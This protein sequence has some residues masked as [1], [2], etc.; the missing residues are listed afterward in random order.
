[1]LNAA[2]ENTPGLDLRPGSSLAEIL[3]DRY[4]QALYG[5]TGRV[6]LGRV[7]MFWPE[8]LPPTVRDALHVSCHAPTKCAKQPQ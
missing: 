8:L 6:K 7:R 5:K 4:S 2:C 3:Q 1:M